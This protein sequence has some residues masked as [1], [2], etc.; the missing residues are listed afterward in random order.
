MEDSKYQTSPLPTHHQPRTGGWDD[1]VG[2]AEGSSG[3]SM[4][5]F[6][7][8]RVVALVLLIGGALVASGTLSPKGALPARSPPAPLARCGAERCAYARAGNAS[9]IPNLVDGDEAV[10]AA[11]DS[12]A[13]PE[14]LAA[15]LGA[16][17][18]KL[19]ATAR[20]SPAPA[21]SPPQPRCPAADG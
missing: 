13:K 10:A 16:R 4:P 20:P 8:R 17:C 19:S 18:H 11:T 2:R 3:C 14:G 6:R 5:R 1:R 9:A 7:F 15:E 21:C 12:D